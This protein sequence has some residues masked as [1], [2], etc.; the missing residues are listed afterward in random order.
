MELQI[1]AAKVAKY[2]VRESGDT[3]EM[4]ER[5]HGGISM[6]LVDGQRSGRSAKIIS[7]IAARKAI[8]LLGEGVRDGA[9]A[10]ATHDYLRTHRGG[11]VS[12]ELQIISV[13]LVT[14]TLV[15][16]RNT[17]CAAYLSA[18]GAAL[19]A[20]DETSRPI[21]IHAST[22]PVIREIELLPW[23]YLI[24][25]TDGLSLA[26]NAVDATELPRRIEVAV[27][28]RWPAQRL[29]DDLLSLALDAEDGRPADD[30]SVVVL[31][32]VPASKDRVRRLSVR[33]PL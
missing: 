11:Q 17:R 26:C 31:A 1:G 27:A 33:F 3:L 18:G 15:L 32:V 5:P 10:R 13:D 29:A 7:N 12:A 2:A 8:S 20:I 30:L 4:I 24:V 16:S 19:Q 28:A 23:T 21:G 22:K 25:A 14:R 9:T 6:V